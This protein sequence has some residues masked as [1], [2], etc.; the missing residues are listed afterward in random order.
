MKRTKNIKKQQHYITSCLP[1][2]Q[3]MIITVKTLQ[4]NKYDLEINLEDSVSEIKRKIHEE[5]KLGEPE[6]QKLIHHG[7]I[8]KDEQTVQSIGF[9]EKDFLVVMIRKMKKKKKKLKPSTSANTNTN[10]TTTTAAAAVPSTNTSSNE[11]TD[12][13]NDQPTD[14]NAASADTLVTGAQL[15]ATIVRLMRM[16]FERAEVVQ[17]L[18]AAFNNPGRAVEYLLNVCLYMLSFHSVFDCLIGYTIQCSTSSTTT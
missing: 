1:T 17:A 16:G 11:N 18:R 7:K 2:K 14:D 8:L 13:S 12:T 5:L 9:K 10:N 4:N 15:D 6:C 3:R